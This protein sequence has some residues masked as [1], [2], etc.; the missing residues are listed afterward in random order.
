MS[1]NSHIEG[2]LTRKRRNRGYTLIELLVVMGILA[3]IG[4]VAVPAYLNHLSKSKIRAA[5]IQIDRLGTILDAYLLDVGRYPT[6]EEGLE[7]L[8]SAP[9]GVDRWAGPYLQ[10]EKSLTDPWG[11]PY[12]Y[13]SPGRHGK[14]DLYSLG[15]DGAEGGDDENKDIT[16]W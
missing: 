5:E 8:V 14:Y 2:R 6:Q 9:P 7:A 11:N 10:K 16:S 12:V 3:V 4:L 13:Q 1:T 15:A